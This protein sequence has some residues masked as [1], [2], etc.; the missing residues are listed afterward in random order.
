M[1]GANPTAWLSYLH[2]SNPLRYGN[3][4]AAVSGG[5]VRAGNALTDRPVVLNRWG[6]LGSHRY[7]VSGVAA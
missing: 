1:L 3:T 5:G 2:H 4:T 6:G 7:P